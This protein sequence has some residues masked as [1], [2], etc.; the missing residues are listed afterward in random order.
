MVDIVRYKSKP[1]KLCTNVFD[2]LQK[3]KDE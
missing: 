3:K 2:H 1:L